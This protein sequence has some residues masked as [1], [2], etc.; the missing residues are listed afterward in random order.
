MLL[1]LRYRFDLSQRWSL[2]T[3][4]DGSFGDSEGTFLV[5]GNFAYTVGKR[6]M[7]RILFGYQYKQAKYKDGDLVTDFTFY[8][9]MAGFDFR[10]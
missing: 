3:H 4:G 9:P 2:L 5:R 10:F 1:G 7:N 6:E 8:G